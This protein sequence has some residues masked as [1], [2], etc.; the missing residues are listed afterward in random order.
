MLKDYLRLRAREKSTVFVFGFAV[1]YAALGC[2]RRGLLPT[3]T[4]EQSRSLFLPNLYSFFLPIVFAF[5]FAPLFL[6]LIRGNLSFFSKP[7]VLVRFG[8]FQ[9]C[10]K[11]QT[12]F[13]LLESAGFVLAQYVLILLRGVPFR[14]MPEFARNAGVLAACAV[15]QIAGYFFCALLFSVL[16]SLLRSTVLGFLL[17]YLFVVA[18][19]FVYC[20]S[21]VGSLLC[22][23]LIFEVP[24]R[25]GAFPAPLLC[26][27]PVLFLLGLLAGHALGRRDFLT[28]EAA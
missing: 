15:L 24:G 1:I 2:F 8:G 14:L 22:D 3:S 10:W 16:A 12:L 20:F 4:P 11:L 21:S 28:K 13:L 7:C 18:D 9:K 6:V 26:A 25:E 5:L 17:T 23:R 27:V 19:Y